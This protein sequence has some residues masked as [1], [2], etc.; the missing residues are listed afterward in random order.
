MIGGGAPPDLFGLPTQLT[1]ERALALV[2]ALEDAWKA[3]AKDAFPLDLQSDLRALTNFFDPLAR[4]ATL[5]RRLD[6]VEPATIDLPPVLALDAGDGRML[7]TPEGRVALELLRTM[8]EKPGATVVVESADVAA[9]TALVADFYRS[10]TRK[11]LDKVRQ[12]AA[13]EAAPMLPVAAAFV[14]LLLVNRS[15]TRE[16]ALDQI[17][18][19][20]E[21]RAVIDD[22]FAPALRAFATTLSGSFKER[23][24]TLRGLSLY[25]GYALT[26]A[27]RRLGSRLRQEESRLWIAEKDEQ[28]VLAFLA[29]DLSRRADSD[30]ILVAFDALVDNYR[31][32][33]PRV[34]NLQLAHERP[35][36]TDDL[37]R[38]LERLLRVS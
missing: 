13:G 32:T 30:R 10:L 35:S 5:R 36:H 17:P 23:D 21:R 11:R 26:E 14:L 15:T 2:A 20:P 4:E 3:Q 8:L 22:A 19:D 9:A 1:R 25:Q 7:V 28:D 31:M 12:L 38:Q 24:R 18:G 16:R 33:L 34:A 37:R 27:R 6:D 29:R